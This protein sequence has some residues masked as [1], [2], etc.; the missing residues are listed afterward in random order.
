MIILKK[1]IL[2]SKD[3]LKCLSE[4]SLYNWNT[5]NK[6][7][8]ILAEVINFVIRRQVNVWYDSA[9]EQSAYNK[10]LFLTQ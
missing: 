7:M 1:E 8:S 3:S 4:H 10:T 2:K 6:Y 9:D 5:I